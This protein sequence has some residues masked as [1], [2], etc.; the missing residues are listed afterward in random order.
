MK[1]LKILAVVVGGVA[2]L[3]AVAVVLAFNSSFQTWAVRKAAAGQPGLTLEVGQVSA[4]MSG[5]D[6]TGFKVV[7]DGMIISAK[8]VNAKFSAWDLITSDQI[9]LESLV[10]T[11]LD[12]DVRSAA[13]ASAPARAPAPAG[14]PG[15]TP[16][17]TPTATPSNAPRPAQSA[18]AATPTPRP[19]APASEKKAPFAGLFEAAKLPV[20]LRV[21]NVSVKGRAHLPQAQTVAFEL[22][23]AGIG[24]GQTG[25]VEWAIDFADAT[26]GADLRAA[27][28][29][30]TA[31]LR[32][33]ADRRIDLVE[34]DTVA[35]PMGPNI[36]N[37]RIQI[38]LKAEKPAGSG[39]E[40]YA[41]GVSLVR[42]TG[43]EPLVKVNAQ[44]LAASREIAGTWDIMVRTEQLAKV[45]A[46]LGLPEVAASG[47]GKFNL[48]PDTTAVAA[49]GD[50]QAQIAKLELLNPGL[51]AL[52]S[53]RVTTR[54]DGGLADN[55][56]RLDQF[57]LEVAGAD[58]RKFAQV[59]VLQKIAY[60]LAEKRVSLAN[61]QAE[62][63][64]ISLFAIP[65]AWAQAFAKPMAI[66][67][68]ELSMVLAVEAEPDGSRV[69]ALTVE[70]LAL[71][72]VTVRDAN[73][74]LLVDRV[75]LSVRPNIDYSAAKLIAKLSEFTVTMP[76]GDSV[77][78]ELTA[79]VTNLSTTP[80]VAFSAQLQARIAQA[81]KPYLSAPTGPL[82]INA[83]VEGRHEGQTL[84]LAKLS[85]TVNRDG[86]VLL[87]ALELLQPIRADLKAST[88]SVPNPAATALRLRL[89][90]I[91]LAWAEPFVAR[92]KLSGNLG[93]G[94]F[95]VAMRTVEDV[96]LTT[97]EPLTLR[98]VTAVIDGKTLAQAL[99]LDAS[100]TATKRGD[101]IAYDLRR[102]E[103]KQGQTSLAALNVAGEAKLGAKL[104]ASAKGNLEADV[105]A[106]MQQPALAA[107]ATLARG[108]VTVAFD[109]SLADA[110][111]A[112]AAIAA[113]NLVAKLE[114][115]ALGD[116][117][118][119]L[120]ATMKPDGSGTVTLPLTLTNGP[121]KSDVAVDGT[122]GKA[123]D[124]KTFL[125]TGKVAS[126]QLFV[127]D[128]QPLAALAPASEAPKT[129]APGTPPPTTPRPSTPAPTRDAEPFWKGVNG[130]FDVD[131]KRVV[132]GKDYIISARGA[133]VV[134]DTRLSLDGLEGKFKDN[135]FKLAAGLNFV[136]QQPKPYALT[137]SA[138]IQN[139]D[140][141]EFLR[142]ANPAEKPALE[143]KATLS[144]K[145]NGTGGNITEVGKNAFGKFELTG[146]KG[147]MYLLERKGS[148]GTLVNLGAT[149][150][151]IFGAARGSDTT[152][153]IGEIAKLLNS[154]QFDTVKLQIERG[155]DLQFK[156]SSLEVLSP[157]LRITGSGTVASK[158]LDDIQNAPMN[159]VLQL[160]AKDQLGFLLQ[161]VRLLGATTDD[162]G[163]NLMSR[164]FTI[165]G[166]PSKPDNSA[167]WKILGEA[168]VGAALGR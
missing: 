76:D 141:G 8:S 75:T 111:S 69:R 22:K 15:A 72:T 136:A 46:G 33:T 53:V 145:L 158:N 100:L 146:S 149:A 168:A 17:P 11:D 120:T 137:G 10:V 86:T 84:Q 5:A 156:L 83:T 115:R 42:A 30:G 82:A 77:G 140:V 122:F 24:A 3:V 45:L 18:P 161:R 66:E 162:K 119:T 97:A 135:P 44:F 143:T 9:N 4:G 25:K 63:A 32:I 74:K 87:A 35:A 38:T 80:V 7:K 48:K 160:G 88:F 43:S 98:A 19:A 62:L 167:L 1:G 163:Y 110:T 37:E 85:T 129:P 106:L 20:D 142:A 134:T 70:P 57:D 103:V 105:A 112:K 58:G 13:A 133:A 50:F 95:E 108:R 47:K 21:G 16:T 139:F 107:Y 155:A 152:S 164:T 128:F 14:A 117:E 153:A 51:A 127:D 61:P 2:V 29:T 78:A 123:S 12:V 154:V 138:D 60:P 124:K 101:N 40:N 27:R 36:P 73:K 68:G 165:G 125:F 67:S 126:N 79:D 150:L 91:P 151:S 131:L 26:A 59:S 147:T 41:A 96:T 71:R 52:G 157:F 93:G 90:E 34:V 54:F 56:A 130:K 166:T 132:Y 159:I 55:V 113:K 121:R 94:T 144:A 104:T 148:A 31:G 28:V 89:G 81:L 102:I 114:N 92:S 23:V 109:A 118:L 6:I 64:R 65:L 99:D 116:V 39:D 49:S